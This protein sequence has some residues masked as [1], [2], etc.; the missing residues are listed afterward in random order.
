MDNISPIDGRYSKKTNELN[1]FFSEF[2]LIKH[3]TYIEC[4]YL[5]ELDNSLNAK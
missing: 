1:M 3:R 2:A 4:Q 5:I